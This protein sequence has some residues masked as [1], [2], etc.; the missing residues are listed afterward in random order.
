MQSGWPR[1]CL[2]PKTNRPVVLVGKVDK[3]SR[4]AKQAE[5]IRIAAGGKSFALFQGV[6]IIK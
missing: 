4:L 1:I 5:L 2:N 3:I 6:L